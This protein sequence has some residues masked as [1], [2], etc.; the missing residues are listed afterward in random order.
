MS[1]DELLEAERRH[2]WHPFTQMEDWNSPGHRPLVIE[3]G[4]GPYLIDSEGTRY[5]DGNSSIWTNIHGHNH[6]TI[7]QAIREQLNKIAH[8]SFLGLTHQPAID[9]GQALANQLDGS[10]LPRVFFSDDGST[11]IECALKMSLQ[12]R[13]LLGMPE[14]REMLAFD[15]HITGTRSVRGPSAASL[16]STTASPCSASQ[17]T[18]SPTWNNSRTSPPPPGA[19]SAPSLSNQ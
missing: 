11:A 7:N 19:A 15:R 13:Q 14:R 6:P 18:G 5:L 4:E 12:N 2:Q 1:P 17:P 3:R 8:S 16:P 9:L 10:P